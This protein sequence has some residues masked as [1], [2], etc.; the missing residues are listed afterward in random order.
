MDNIAYTVKQFAKIMN[1]G[2][3]A[4]Y[5]LVHSKNFPKLVVGKKILVPKK[6]LEQWIDKN[7]AV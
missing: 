4:A 7:I 2:M 1:I 6:A 5:D 3:N